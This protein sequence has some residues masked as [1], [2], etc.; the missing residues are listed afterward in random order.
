MSD[1]S[2]NGWLKK[3]VGWGVNGGAKSP[4]KKGGF[5]ATLPPNYAVCCV[6]CA[7][8]GVY[9]HF[10]LDPFFAFFVEPAPAFWVRTPREDLVA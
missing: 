5:V 4:V 10:R 2:R 7:V 6:P 3:A 1:K 8:C 9:L